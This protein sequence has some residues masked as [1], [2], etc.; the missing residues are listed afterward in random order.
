MKKSVLLLWI[1]FFLP[2]WGQESNPGFR[3]ERV[4]KVPAKTLHISNKGNTEAPVSGQET[5]S[6][7][8]KPRR[9]HWIL[10]GSFGMNFGDYTTLNVSPQ[11]GY[12]WNNFFTTGGGVNYSYYSTDYYKLHYMGLNIF[13]R[14]RVLQ[15]I[16]FQVQPEL[17]RRWGTLDGQTMKSEMVPSLLLGAGGPIPAGN[18]GGVSIMFYYDVLQ[19]KYTPYGSKIFYSIGYSFG[20]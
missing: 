8:T 1:L 15:Y 17:Q 4:E 20:F 18:N 5:E 3:F 14:A 16:T 2:V 6:V 13:A 19:S 9:G 7:R 11:V 10:G 12:S